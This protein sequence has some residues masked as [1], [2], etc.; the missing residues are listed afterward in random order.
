M[1]DA[2]LT[3]MSE[4]IRQIEER[5]EEVVRAALLDSCPMRGCTAMVRT[6]RWVVEMGG[7]PPFVERLVLSCDA[8]HEW[9]QRIT[10]EFE[11]KAVTL[12]SVRFPVTFEADLFREMEEAVEASVPGALNEGHDGR[13]VDCP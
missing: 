9:Y 12:R 6:A 8:G 2:I 4:T 3:V 13:K 10:T 1:M 11:G 5:K 7:G